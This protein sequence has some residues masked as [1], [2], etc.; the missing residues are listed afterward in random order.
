MVG[1]PLPTGF[2]HINMKSVKIKKGEIKCLR[3]KEK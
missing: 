2:N 3:L 1:C